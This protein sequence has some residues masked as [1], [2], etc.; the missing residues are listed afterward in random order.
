MYL[1]E[2]NVE[3][4]FKPLYRTFPLERE[5]RMQAIH[6]CPFSQGCQIFIATTYQNWG[7]IYHITWKFTKC[8]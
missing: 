5:S 3:N 1:S 6:M 4:F 7:K 2:I 8:P